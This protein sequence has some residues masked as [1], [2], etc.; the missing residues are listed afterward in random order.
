[1]GEVSFRSKFPTFIL[2]DKTGFDG[3]GSD[4]EELKGGVEDQTTVEPK[5]NQPIWHVCS[6]RK[7]EDAC[8]KER[9]PA[10]NQ[11]N[12]FSYSRRG[13]GCSMRGANSLMKG[14]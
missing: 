9:G 10:G 12:R 7:R 8:R 11:E 14:R 6:R 3:Q 13:R 1:M 2:E 4:K 5:H